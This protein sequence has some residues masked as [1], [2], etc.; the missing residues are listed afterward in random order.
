MARASVAD[1][2]QHV[3]GEIELLRSFTVAKGIDDYRADPTLRRAVERSLEIIRR[4]V[5]P[6]GCGSFITRTDTIAAMALVGRV[7]LAMPVG[8]TI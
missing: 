8:P 5:P 7:G 2:L 6:D 4:G 3:L 1:R